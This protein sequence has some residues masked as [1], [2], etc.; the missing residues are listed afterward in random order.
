MLSLFFHNF[1]ALLLL[2]LLV[3]LLWVARRPAC[4]CVERDHVHLDS[5]SS[6]TNL[7][8]IELIGPDVADVTLDAATCAAIAQQTQLTKIAL[9]MISTHSADCSFL[10]GLQQ[11]QELCVAAVS[12]AALPVLA[13]LT[14]LTWL[15]CDWQQQQQQPAGSAAATLQCP[16]VRSLVTGV[17]P[18]P[19]QFFPNV[20]ELVQGAGW[21]P[22]AFMSLAQ[23]CKRLTQL[24]ISSHFEEDGGFFNRGSLTRQASA[25]DCGA[26][27]KSLS[28]LQRLT[29]LSFVPND[30]A[31]V[32]T[33]SWPKALY[34]ACHN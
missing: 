3:V 30:R 25:A 31:E 12:P 5:I 24:H 6:L 22:S 10:S 11:L 9:G 33:L 27:V 29:W 13:S 1:Y 8:S 15:E 17:Y 26:A 7:R 23:H 18:V 4:S 16:S 28:A 19:I 21:R 14:Q 2:L 32:S 34:V 20:E